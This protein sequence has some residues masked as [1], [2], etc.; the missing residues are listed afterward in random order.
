MTQQFIKTAE[1]T[2][3]RPERETI[4]QK[5]EIISLKIDLNLLSVEDFL[6]K[7]CTTVQHASPMKIFY[8]KR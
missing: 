4:I 3:D 7:Y 8:R 6:E 2:H 5:D 1:C